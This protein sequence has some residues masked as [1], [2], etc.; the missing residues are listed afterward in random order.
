MK[1]FKFLSLLLTLTLVFNVVAPV[2]HAADLNN[3]AKA[4]MSAEVTY[5][6]Y[7]IKGVENNNV[8][9]NIFIN[10][11]DETGQFAIVYLDSPDYMYEFVFNLSD[12][13][14]R[15]STSNNLWEEVR[16]YCFASEDLWTEVYLPSAVTVT[17]TAEVNSF[18][19]ATTPTRSTETDFFENWLIS[20]HGNEYSGNL[21]TTKTQSGITMYLKSAFQVYAYKDYTYLLNQTLTVVGFVT[22]IL[23][24]SASA[25]I[26]GVLGIIAGTGGLFTLKQSVYLYKARA[27]WFKY[28][29]C[30]SGTGY[31]YGLTDKFTF[32]NGYCYSGTG[33]CVV[34]SASA[35]TSY[36]PSSTVY[37]SNTN[38]FNAAF[39][40]Y[41][42]IGFQNGNF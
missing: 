24:F 6:E 1:K 37:N 27:N 7:S 42:R 8:R 17:Q 20:T 4:Q 22:A 5:E 29:T 39:D 19:R 35:S 11:E 21:I 15:S 14:R 18:Q 23:G 30:V 28:A 10:N 31:P 36:V 9:F 25:P 40:E 13:P 32:Y 12:V 38:I 3:P 33:T 2:A 34:D 41:Q 26:V 16:A